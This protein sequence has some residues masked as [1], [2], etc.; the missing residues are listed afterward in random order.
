MFPTLTAR[1]W[2]KFSLSQ[3]FALSPN[4]HFADNTLVK[5]LLDGNLSV[6]VELS[7]SC[8]VALAAMHHTGAR[9]QSES[10][11]L[12]ALITVITMTVTV[13]VTMHMGVQSESVYV[14]VPIT[15]IVPIA[16]I[17]PI[18][19]RDRTAAAAAATA[20]EWVAP[21]FLPD[22]EGGSAS[23]PHL[24]SPTDDCSHPA[25]LYIHV[26]GKNWNFETRSLFA[27]CVWCA[28]SLFAVC[29][30]CAAVSRGRMCCVCSRP[31][32]PRLPPGST[33]TRCASW[34]ASP[35]GSKLG[36]LT[37]PLDLTHLDERQRD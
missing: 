8:S 26:C 37:V 9:G 29:V 28:V 7:S 19:A 13:T 31:L 36:L 33:P 24:V 21:E 27:V 32:R 35:R 11:A 3:R 12:S 25:Q 4:N 30:W 15:S 22:A 18:T 6:R 2:S 10:S 23:P 1:F 34:R 5:F 16:R 20:V 17:A 14:P